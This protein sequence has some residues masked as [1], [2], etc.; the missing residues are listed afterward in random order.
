VRL[1]TVLFWCVVAVLGLPALA[2][3]LT[4]LVDSDVGTLIRLESFTPFGLPLY[5][6]TAVVLVAGV[7]VATRRRARVVALVLAVVGLAL[8]AW[9]YAPQVTGA[10]PAPAA[11]ADHLVVMNSNML[12]GG[13][14]ADD[15]VAAVERD[16]VDLLVTE[17]ITPDALSR[18][19]AAGLSTYLPH[20]AGA[21]DQYVAGTMVF[22]AQPITDV[23]QLATTFNSYRVTVDGLTVLAVHPLAPTVPGGWV[24]E[25][26]LLQDEALAVKADLVVGDLNATPDHDVLR[27]M[28]D[29]GYRD[30]AELANEGW[31]P[32][33]PANHL[34]ILPLLPSVVRIDHVLLAP[35]M[36]SLGTH[37]VDVRGTDHLALVATVARR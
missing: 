12:A 32:T 28:A 24:R 3:T 10:N 9:W 15:I 8:H 7:V 1:R 20:Q 18:L 16:H 25:H 2:L 31:Q 19:E 4:R 22:A 26:A 36:A 29:H 27:S 37:T 33:W 13:A 34:G 6:A 30:A 17:E 35:T 5:A 14:N 11:G 23:A 21:P